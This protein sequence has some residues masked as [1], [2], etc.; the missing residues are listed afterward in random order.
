MTTTNLLL[1]LF[2]HMHWADARVWEAALRCEPAR[3]DAALR[4]NLLHL[5]GVQRGFLD[6]WTNQPFNFRIN[7]E[8]TSLEREYIAV[9]GYYEPAR[10]FLASL[11]ADDLS[12]PLIVPWKTWA[13]RALGRPVADTS[14][15]ETVLQVFMHSTHHRA[16]ANTRL[17]AL[18]AAPPL[19]DYIAWLWLGRPQA[20]WSESLA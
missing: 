13:E 1:D 11:N 4:D 19:V 5:H 7:Y 16:Q 2:D 10:A 20:A 6:A 3:N 12:R 17:R 8:D 9:R 18:G 14:L 15:S